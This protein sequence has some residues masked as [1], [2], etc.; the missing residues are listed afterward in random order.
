MVDIL[1][2]RWWNTRVRSYLAAL[3]VAL[4]LGLAV[5]IDANPLVLK[6]TV[7]DQVA[8]TLTGSSS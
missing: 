8:R 2:S 6:D 7:T 3:S 4:I 1:Q 5:W